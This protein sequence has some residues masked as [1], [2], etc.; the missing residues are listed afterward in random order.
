MVTKHVQYV[1][2]REAARILKA[3]MDQWN[4]IGVNLAQDAEVAPGQR[5]PDFDVYV[6]RPP[7]ADSSNMTSPQSPRKLAPQVSANGNGDS[8]RRQTSAVAQV[9][10]LMFMCSQCNLHCAM[11]F[12]VDLEMHLGKIPV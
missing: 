2:W 11:Y 4:R 6:E 9:R 1:N 12:H 7:P 5:K 10:F 3:I 8:L